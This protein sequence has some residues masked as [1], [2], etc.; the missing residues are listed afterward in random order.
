MG[1]QGDLVVLKPQFSCRGATVILEANC[2]DFFR[3]VS[4]SL[5]LPIERVSS[6]LVS[7]NCGMYFA[8]IN[9]RPLMASNSLAMFDYSYQILSNLSWHAPMSKACSQTDCY[10]TLK[11]ELVFK[12]LLFCPEQEKQGQTIPIQGTI[13]VAQW[14]TNNSFDQGGLPRGLHTRDDHHRNGNLL[15]KSGQ[16]KAPRK[17]PS[18]DILMF[19]NSPPYHN[20]Q[21]MCC[22]VFLAMR[23]SLS[24]CMYVLV[25]NT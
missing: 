2:D 19:S 12:Q 22:S 16:T 4:P 10:S 18:S 6:F 8:Q 25:A 7:A 11:S 21:S 14:K 23:L 17:P 15:P 20:S 3:A 1:V 13:R 5:S 24:L 9:Y